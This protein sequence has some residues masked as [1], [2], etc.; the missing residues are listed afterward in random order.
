MP[1]IRALI[2]AAGSGKRAS[3]P[4][5]KTL[6]PVEGKPIL[7]RLLELLR[8]FDP[9]PTVVVSPSGHGAVARCLKEAGA[10]AEIVEQLAPTGMGDA[11]LCFRNSPAYPAADHLLVVWGDIPF[12]EHAT[13][14]QLCAA[15]LA[16]DNDFTFV[17]R[18]AEA[19]YTIVTRDDDGRVNGVVETR[20]EGL[21]PGPGERDIGLFIFRTKPLLELLEKRLPGAIG[22][23]TGEHGFLY[24]VRQ[25][26][27]A[28]FKVD[29]LPIAS[30]R[31][32]VSL[33]RLADL[34]EQGGQ[35]ER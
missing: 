35:Q 7:V 2:A 15:H 3:L 23:S 30:A 25:A 31:E 19:A 13:V 11:I 32:C 8:P 14:A 27:E 20:E 16:A 12:L 17:T 5:P 34:T 1:E 4:Y 28:G 29:A 22:R 10:D 18:Q 6:H 26:A 9:R 33:N 24:I 21:E